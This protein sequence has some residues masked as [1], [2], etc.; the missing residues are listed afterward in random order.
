[1][2][3]EI[4]NM[5]L[6]ADYLPTITTTTG[7]GSITTTVNLPIVEQKHENKNCAFNGSLKV[8]SQ[9]NPY[10]YNV[11]VMLLNDI[12]TGNNWRYTDM[13]GHKDGFVDTPILIA[14]ADGKVGDGHNYTEKIDEN[15]NVYP[16]FTDAKAE[17]IVG[18]FKSA[19]DIR[20]ETIDGVQWIIG[21][22]QIW[23]YYA[24]ELTNLLS[25]QGDRGMDVSIETLV[26]SDNIVMDGDTEVFNDYTILGTTI[27]GKGVSPAVAGAYIRELSLSDE[28]EKFELRVASLKES[29][30]EN[31]PQEKKKSRKD[32]I[33]MSKQ[34]IADMQAR[35]PEHKVLSVSEDG[36]SVCLAEMA[37]GKIC[38]YVFSSK[39]DMS[40][41]NNERIET[42]LV[43]ATIVLSNGAEMPFD[44]GDVA[45]ELNS[46]LATAN[47]DVAR[48]Q[49]EL[50]AVNEKINAMIVAET[51]RRIQSAKD[52]VSSKLV[53]INANRTAE[54]QIDSKICDP[55]I[56]DVEK[57]I[58][59]DCLD[60]NGTWCGD[61]KAVNDL[62]AKCMEVQADVDRKNNA[63]SKKQFIWESFAK[64]SNGEDSSIEALLARMKS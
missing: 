42:G 39:E 35:F 29:L 2:E 34:A 5:Y 48:L 54:M 17:R 51:A 53:E 31:K 12:T 36:M 43:N 41:V 49:G 56:A 6:P 37:T 22:G 55:I 10:L 47:N 24:F 38:G 4:T 45:E 19:E 3:E 23:S 63:A 16:S 15:G 7:T 1:M 40:S 58:Y 18:W 8:L 9:E 61:K 13:E 30:D 20:V 44:I 21:K 60:D 52:A 46:K 33:T 62:L 26:S 32:A 64:N 28:K 59:N 11:E 25:E 50:N 14:Y 57:G 27:L